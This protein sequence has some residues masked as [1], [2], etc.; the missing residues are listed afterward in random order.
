MDVGL[1]QLGAD[2]QAHGAAVGDEPGHA[3]G[4]HGQGAAAEEAGRAVVADAG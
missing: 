2:Q 4:G 1:V 3:S